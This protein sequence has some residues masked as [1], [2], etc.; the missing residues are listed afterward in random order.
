M[1]PHK[2]A[3]P[4]ELERRL[5]EVE[6]NATLNEI[7]RAHHRNARLRVIRIQQDRTDAAGDL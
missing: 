6:M 4:I 3:S 2:L 7:A 5:R 1:S